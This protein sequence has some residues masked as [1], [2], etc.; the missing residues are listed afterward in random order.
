LDKAQQE[1][2]SQE[3]IEEIMGNAKRLEEE[4]NEIRNRPKTPEPEMQD[5]SI[6][7]QESL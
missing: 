3:Q 4:L 5:E 6:M 1:K 7:M 2:T